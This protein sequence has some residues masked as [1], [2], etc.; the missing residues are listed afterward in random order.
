ML[1]N[2]NFKNPIRIAS[3][4][5]VAVLGKDAL[6]TM[7]AIA[8]HFAHSLDLKDKGLLLI[9]SPD[10]KAKAARLATYLM[11]LGGRYG[12]PRLAFAD[13]KG[14]TL[15]DRI[16]LPQ[17]SSGIAFNITPSTKDQNAF[18][19]AFAAK[20]GAQIW[21]IGGPAFSRA[22]PKEPAASFGSE[23]FN[24]L[25]AIR[26]RGIVSGLGHD[27]RANGKLEEELG[28]VIARLSGGRLDDERFQSDPCPAGSAFL[29]ALRDEGFDARHDKDQNTG[30]S[31][32]FVQCGALGVSRRA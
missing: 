7:A 15:L 11:D 21:T 23:A 32:V 14:R 6:S 25:D 3:G 24:P 8:G 30:G 2:S 31:S 12:E 26:V 5:L 17:D 13:I 27:K 22:W 1:A 28:N 18:M 10:L 29:Q 19:I 16:E 4:T 20:A 9:C